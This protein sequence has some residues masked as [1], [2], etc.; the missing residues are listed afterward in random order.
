MPRLIWGVLL[1]SV[2]I[3]LLVAPH[4][5]VLQI[6]VWRLWPLF[7]IVSGIGKMTSRLPR[8]RREGGPWL[9]ALGAWLLLNTLT[10]WQFRETWPVLV[11]FLEV[12]MIWTS[13]PAHRTLDASLEPK[14]VD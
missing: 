3:A 5:N 7:L 1:V 4:V 14:H 2:G 10:D 11:M 8:R 13:F 12:K 9:V 6:S